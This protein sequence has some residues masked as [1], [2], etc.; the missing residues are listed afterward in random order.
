MCRRAAPFYFFRDVGKFDAADPRCRSGEVA[1]DYAAVDADRLEYLR[2]TVTAERR[3]AHLGHDFEQPLV[4]GVDVV[5]DGARRIELEL[6]DAV[7]ADGFECQIRLI[8][9]APKPRR[10][11]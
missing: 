4:D 1:V 2:R 6:A 10:S 7:G 11:A 9:V 8:A 5:F 3:D